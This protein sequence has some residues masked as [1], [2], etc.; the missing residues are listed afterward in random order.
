LSSWLKNISDEKMSPVSF[1]EWCAPKSHVTI[2]QPV[3]QLNFP[4]WRHLPQ[5][6]TGQGYGYSHYRNKRAFTIRPKKKQFIRLFDKPWT[7]SNG[8]KTNTYR[9]CMCLKNCGETDFYVDRF[10]VLETL[11][12][13]HD[14]LE[15]KVFRY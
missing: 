4:F 2:V 12:S 7:L 9:G 11:V 15:I 1:Y 10:T 5:P 8:I 6:I 14:Q 3:S 13:N